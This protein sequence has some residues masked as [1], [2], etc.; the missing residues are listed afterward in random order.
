MCE[1]YNK[2]KHDGVERLARSMETKWGVIK[3]DIVKFCNCYQ[4]MVV[5]DE[6][7]ISHENT[8]LKEVEL[9]KLKHLKHISFTFINYWFMLKDMPRWANVGDDF[10]KLVP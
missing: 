10:K 3:H 5:L 6:S 4:S 2:N 8:L 1:D 7:R 9:Y